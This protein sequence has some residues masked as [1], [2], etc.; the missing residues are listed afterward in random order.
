MC[1]RGNRKFTRLLLEQRKARRFRFLGVQ[2]AIDAIPVMDLF[3]L[4]SQRLRICA[5]N[6]IVQGG[7]PSSWNF[8]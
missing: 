4:C 3:Q 2:L 6:P 7:F 1:D 8:E 5:T